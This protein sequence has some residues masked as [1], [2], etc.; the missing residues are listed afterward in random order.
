MATG[1]LTPIRG[2]DVYIGWTKQAA[3]GTPLAPTF[4]WRWLDGSEWNP[5]RKMTSEREGDTSPFISISWATAQMGLVKIVEYARPITA[6]CALQ[7]FLGSGSDTY[8]APTKSTT[9]A[10]AV[11]LPATTFQST[12]DL[13]SVGTMA[14]AIEGGYASTTGE[15][16][17]VNLV[18]RTGTGPYTY[19]LNGGASFARAH[20]NSGTI[21][22]QA[23]HAFTRQIQ[24]YDPY[25]LEWAYGH[26]GGTPA[27]AWRLQDA[28]CTELKISGQANRPIKFEHT[29]YGALSKL[30]AAL[31]SPVYEGA[32][33]FGTPSGPF[34]YDQAGT[35][36]LIDGAG[37][38]NA[39]TIGKFDLTMKNSTDVNEFVTEALTPAYF[40]PSNFDVSANLDVVFQSFAQYN[41]AF[42]GSASPATGASDSTIVGIGSFQATFTADAINSLL[43]NL[44]NGAYQGP[45]LT[46]KLDAKAIHQPIQLVGQRGAG[47]TNPFAATLTNAQ[48]SQ[49]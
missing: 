47:I 32:G 19:T 5:D 46:P 49:Y 29:W 10:A 36:W 20:S 14:V 30:Q 31:S 11:T 25:T 34:R 27:Q 44:L 6:G 17:N 7:A 12:A 37:T 18:S 22:S 1:G 24:T 28:V 4:F 45:K 3:W 40:I 16:V 21:V 35:S 33:V 39:A 38:G 26:A 42:F 41:E 8:T 23:S 2:N 13:G 43:L 48:A 15:V 9:L